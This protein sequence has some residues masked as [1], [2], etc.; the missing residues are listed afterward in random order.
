MKNHLYWIDFAK[1]IGLLLMI[2]VH[3]NMVNDEFRC[4]IYSFHMPLFFI[5]SGLLTRT[6]NGGVKLSQVSK[7]N[8]RALMI[9]YFCMNLFCLLF[10]SFVEYFKGELGFYVLKS[11][12]WAILLGV[13]YNINSIRPVCTAM[14][15][16][17]ALFI[18]KLLYNVLPKN[19]LSKVIQV[20]ICFVIVKILTSY[21]IDTYVPLDSAIMAYPFFIAGTEIKH[22]FSREI[23]NKLILFFVILLI[24]LATYFISSSNGRCDIDTMRYGKFYSLFLCTGIC[25][26]FAILAVCSCLNMQLVGIKVFLKNICNGAPLIVG[27]NLLAINAFK[28]GLL[29]IVKQW[30]SIY[31]IALG[32]V[33]ILAFYPI[34][35]FTKKRFPILI[36]FR[37]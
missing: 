16:F 23:K 4:Y 36:G 19:R 11:H 12:I 31:G 14:W 33:I 8:F 17:Y 25:T 27:L 5:I 20:A 6:P 29:H 35:I 15:F 3:G 22:F 2:I 26:S 30:S 13:G 37:K 10:F 21:N 34:I 1:T 7:K 9:P 18:V 24:L 28:T 32:I